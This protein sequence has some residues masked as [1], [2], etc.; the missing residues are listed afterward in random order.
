MSSS[1][2]ASDIA[3]A[4][5]PSAAEQDVT[6]RWADARMSAVAPLSTEEL[7]A[8]EADRTETYSVVIPPPN[9][10][11]ALHLGHALNSTL[12]DV[13]I[14]YHWMLGHRTL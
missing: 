1:N 8:D 13:L 4:Y 14:R 9:V 12:Q 3:I 10:T 2:P 11:V 5:D 6:K 7:A